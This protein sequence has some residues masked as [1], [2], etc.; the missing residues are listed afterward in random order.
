MIAFIAG[1]AVGV[2]GDELVRW[3]HANPD[4]A[5]ALWNKV[6]GR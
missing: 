3:V 2:V 1:L 6:R 5:K 4:A